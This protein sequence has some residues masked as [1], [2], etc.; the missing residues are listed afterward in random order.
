MVSATLLHL[1]MERQNVVQYT[2]IIYLISRIG[3]VTGLSFFLLFLFFFNDINLLWLDKIYTKLTR[4]DRCLIY[5][6]IS[7]GRNVKKLFLN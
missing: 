4:M 6:Y 5:F 2:F 3:S 7:V 1:E